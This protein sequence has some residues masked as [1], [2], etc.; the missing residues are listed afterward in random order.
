MLK[1]SIFSFKFGWQGLWVA[2]REEHNLIM[3]LIIGLAGLILGLLF[4]IS[5]TDWTLGVV[6]WGMTSAMELTN[7][8]LEEVVDSFTSE[9]HPG[10]KKAKDI[11][12]SAVM[13]L[14]FIEVIVGLLIFGPHFLGS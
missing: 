12:A 3:Q 10:A 8:A 6:T 11:A 2:F 13:L 1:K 5:L 4:Q 14:F 9:Q 7:T